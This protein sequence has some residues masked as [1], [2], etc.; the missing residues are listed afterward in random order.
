MRLPFSLYTFENSILCVFSIYGIHTSNLTT[1]ICFIPVLPS[2]FTRLPLEVNV[3]E[4][5]ITFATFFFAWRWVHE[6]SC[7]FTFRC[8]FSNSI[9]YQIFSCCNIPLFCHSVIF[10]LYGLAWKA[11]R[12][13]PALIISVASLSGENSVYGRL[14]ASLSCCSISQVH[15]KA[16]LFCLW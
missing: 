4:W 1:Y 13:P 9:F 12:K 11:I 15:S 6:N 5:E 3:F 7:F 2:A 16:M 10:S 14:L 8:I